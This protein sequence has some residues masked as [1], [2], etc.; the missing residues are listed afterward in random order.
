MLASSDNSATIRARAN[1]PSFLVWSM[2]FD[3]GWHATVTGSNGVVAVVKVHRVGLL[4]AVAVPRGLSV[5]RFTYTPAGFSTG[6][7]LSLLA[8][9]ALLIGAL[10]TG[11]LSSRRRS[12]RV[13][14][15]QR[16]PD[17]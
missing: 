1:A 15:P 4:D 6:L 3:V 12:T 10:A 5:V 8:L 17:R 9:G 14:R 16:V 2:T 13:R 7:A 11:L